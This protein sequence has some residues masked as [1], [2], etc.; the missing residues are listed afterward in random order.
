MVDFP[1]TSNGPH[2]L[3]NKEYMEKGNLL[4]RTECCGNSLCQYTCVLSSLPPDSLVAEIEGKNPSQI[5]LTL[6]VLRA[7]LGSRDV[8]EV[9]VTS[10]NIGRATT[11]GVGI[12]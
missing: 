8:E 10:S 6:A 5:S 12:R 2:L 1:T 7:E 11:Y 9:P 4:P 3:E